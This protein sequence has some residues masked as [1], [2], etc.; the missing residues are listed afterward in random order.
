[1]RKLKLEVQLSI[2]GFMADQKGGT[3]WMVWNWGND[4]TW[5]KE[6]Q[7]YHT[8]LTKSAD[9]IFL[10]RQMA[11]EGFIEHWAQV[12]Q[13]A[14][15][16]Q[17]D[18]AKHIR[19]TY[20]VIF[21]KTLTKDDPIPG[22]WDNADV[23]QWDIKQ[24][25]RHLKN[26]EGKDIIVYGGASF[27]S[28][29][30]QGGLVDEYHLLINPVVLGKGIPVFNRLPSKQSMILQQSKTYSCGVTLMQYQMA[31]QSVEAQVA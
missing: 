20:K 1:M 21:S 19:D 13:D 24:H 2:D 22:G 16:P 7:D 18:F 29:L 5:D 31:K 26:Q 14:S 23:S 28:S 27:I 11:E 6:L 17:Q 3:D 4:W 9:C 30:I 10:S 15:S 25:I 12:A 8:A